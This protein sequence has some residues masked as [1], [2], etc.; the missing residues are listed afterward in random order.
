MRKIIVVAAGM[1]VLMLGACD[2]LEQIAMNRKPIDKDH[3]DRVLAQITGAHAAREFISETSDKLDC[4]PLSSNKLMETAGY[5]A[6][7]YSDEYLIGFKKECERMA[8]E[9]TRDTLLSEA[10]K[11]TSA[12]KERLAALEAMKSA[13]NAP[14]P[15]RRAA[16]ARRSMAAAGGTERR[17]EQKPISTY[18]APLCPCR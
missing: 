12:N 10:A 18:D 15:Q 16:T 3:K 9:K 7:K 2:Q 17:T 14:T 13:A 1:A 8:K 5:R 4:N 6:A 11:Q